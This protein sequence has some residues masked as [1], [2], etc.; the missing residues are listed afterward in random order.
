MKIKV[1]IMQKA[2][3]GKQVAIPM[4]AFSEKDYEQAE[5][6]YK[7]VKETEEHDSV[8]A[9]TITECELGIEM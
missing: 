4:R 8:L 2:E 7:T 9:V 5:V 1:I 3:N 6:Y